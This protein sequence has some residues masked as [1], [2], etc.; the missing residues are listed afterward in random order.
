MKQW[1]LHEKQEILIWCKVFY[2]VN[3]AMQWCKTDLI[4]NVCVIY[5]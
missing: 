3:M 5:D 4:C 2:Q 1:S